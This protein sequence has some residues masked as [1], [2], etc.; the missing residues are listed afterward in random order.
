MDMS[1]GGENVMRDHTLSSWMYITR[2]EEIYFV[3][4]DNMSKKGSEY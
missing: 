2:E 1:C 3:K 4:D